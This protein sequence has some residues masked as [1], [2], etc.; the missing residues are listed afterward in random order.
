MSIT[1][2]FNKDFYTETASTRWHW[3][4]SNEC[5]LYIIFIPNIGILLILEH[6]F[7]LHQQG[8]CPSLPTIAQKY[9]ELGS[10]DGVKKALEEVFKRYGKASQEEK[11]EMITNVIHQNHM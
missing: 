5:L 6:S 7:H 8:V 9:E 1:P 2:I 10:Q 4:V 11:V 3:Y